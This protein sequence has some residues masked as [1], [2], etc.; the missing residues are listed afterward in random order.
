MKIKYLAILAALSASMFLVCIYILTVKFHAQQE[1][2]SAEILV[3]NIAPYTLGSTVFGFLFLF[4]IFA[5]LVVA[6]RRHLRNKL[7]KQ[8]A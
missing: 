5:I 2:I 7:V 4:S 3:K 8:S 6:I 1:P